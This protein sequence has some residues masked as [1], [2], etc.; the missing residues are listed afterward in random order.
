VTYSVIKHGL[1]GLTKYLAA[2]WAGSGVRVNA[3]SPGGV[4]NAQ[5]E[6]FVKRL[7]ELIPMGRMARREEYRAAV[8]FLCSDASAYMT[9]QNI[10]MDGGRSIL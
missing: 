1:V 2:Y 4:Y 3:L 6:E 7:T 8:Q 9:G 10:I 5:G